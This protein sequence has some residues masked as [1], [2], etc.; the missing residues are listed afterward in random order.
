PLVCHPP[1]VGKLGAREPF[2]F[3]PDVRPLVYRVQPL[4]Q[5][6]A[7]D[8]LVGR[9]RRLPAFLTVHP[10]GDPPRGQFLAGQAALSLVEPTAS[11]LWAFHRPTS[12]RVERRGGRAARSRCGAHLAAES[13]SARA[14]AWRRRSSP[15]SRKTV[16]R[17]RCLNSGGRPVRGA[18]ALERTLCYATKS[19]RLVFSDEPGDAGGRVAHDSLG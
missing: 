15:S 17:T 12:F 11:V 2:A 16:S 19:T 14:T 3:R 9:V 6:P 8:V 7:G 1:A 10:V 5:E 4:P 13:R 18:I